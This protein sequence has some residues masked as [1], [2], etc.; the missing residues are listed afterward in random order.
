[1]KNK[2]IILISVIGL[3]IIGFF[4]LYNS[5]EITN[6]DK[7]KKEDNTLK[8]GAFGTRGNYL[9]KTLKRIVPQ[10]IKNFM[11]DT[12]FVFKKVSFLEQELAKKN[13]YILD[14]LND[15]QFFVFK[16]K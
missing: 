5:L 6:Y 16:K 11:R 15:T 4:S 2:K 9:N 12:I 3:L 14:Y 1:M 8:G 7:N 13:K 10:N